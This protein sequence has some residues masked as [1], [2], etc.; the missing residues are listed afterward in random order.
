MGE[1]A[2]GAADSAG[3]A[4]RRMSDDFEDAGDEA[5]EAFR[6][7]GRQSDSLGTGIIKSMGKAAKETKS[8]TQDH[9]VRI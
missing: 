9:T 6:E 5:R 7:I 1:D 3:S 2:T 4:A 8:V